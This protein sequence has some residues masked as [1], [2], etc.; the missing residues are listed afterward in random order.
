M[1]QLPQDDDLE[2]EL[3][4]FS[5]K[6]SGGGGYHEDLDASERAAAGYD[7][8]PAGQRKQKCSV[9][10]SA[11]LA[12]VS[13]LATVIYFTTGS[14]TGS[15][16][17]SITREGVPATSVC[18]KSPATEERHQKI[19]LSNST[20]YDV[21]EEMQHDSSSFTQGLTYG[22]GLL[23][24]S[25]GLYGQS[26]VR[27][28]DPVTGDVLKSIDMDPSLFAE[29][30]TYYDDDR[31]IQITW[32]ARK[33]FI[34]R[35]STLELLSVFEFETNT[36]E[37]WGITFDPCTRALIVSDGSEYL[38]FW[39]PENPGVD[40]KR[41][42]KVKRQ[43][44]TMK[45]DQLNELE[46]VNGK[47]IANVWYEDILLVINPETGECEDEYDLSRLWPKKER[48][49]AGAD[50]LNGV[51]VSGEDGILY[52]TGKLWKKLFRLQLR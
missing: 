19:Y 7:Y 1:M 20:Q 27:Q 10:F 8:R 9:V 12:V 13:V 16:S 17:A 11:A 51:S 34:Y 31:L 23:Y 47:V 38:H 52:V 18:S 42:V 15:S 24:E 6:V 33:G 5:D 50:V 46:F 2:V 32:K 3:S 22:N 26:K 36:N 25:V 44:P 45:A 30:M 29:G 40:A 41:R 14:S 35:A 39:D 49:G 4:D 28:L 43:D 37:G 48:K 21:L